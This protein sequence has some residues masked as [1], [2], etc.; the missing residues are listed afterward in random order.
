MYSSEF[1]EEKKNTVE[2]FKKLVTLA[3]LTSIVNK[4]NTT[5]KHNN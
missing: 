2:Q 4:Y 1:L 3:P 5:L